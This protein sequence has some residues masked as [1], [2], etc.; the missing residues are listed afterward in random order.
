MAKPMRIPGK[1][2]WLVTPTVQSSR[3]PLM[4]LD[5]WLHSFQVTI[6]GG[7]L[8]LLSLGLVIC[9]MGK[10]LTRPSLGGH[11][12]VNSKPRRGL[13]LRLPAGDVAPSPTSGSS[14]PLQPQLPHP[15]HQMGRDINK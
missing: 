8:T 13:G 11:W 12:C 2:G 15:S 7:N 4:L 9:K 14:W 1:R 10:D 3:R 5:Q 6:L